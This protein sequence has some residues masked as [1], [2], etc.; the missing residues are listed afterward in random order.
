MTFSINQSI[1]E[2]YGQM[3]SIFSIEMPFFCLDS[4]C[5]EKKLI[6]Q[7][8]NNNSYITRQKKMRIFVALFTVHDILNTVV[9]LC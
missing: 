7:K 8:K 6:S 4:L 5:D 1:C 9:D 2:S 3:W